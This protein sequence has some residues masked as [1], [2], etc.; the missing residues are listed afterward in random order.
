M[1]ASNP[2]QC[3]VRSMLSLWPKKEHFRN[4]FCTHRRC[5]SLSTNSAS[6]AKSNSTPRSISAL[7][8]SLVFSS[9]TMRRQLLYL[10]VLSASNFSVLVS[11]RPCWGQSVKCDVLPKHYVPSAMLV[12]VGS[13]GESGRRR[14][15]R[16]K[17]T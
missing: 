15:C 12:Y 8:A 3:L 9:G 1:A 7:N 16:S 4:A 2:C 13:S 6:E 5:I 10:L 17:S 11:S 14:P